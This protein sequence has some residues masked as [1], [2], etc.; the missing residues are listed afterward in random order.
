MGGV[1]KGLSFSKQSYFVEKFY[2]VVG[3]LC[4]VGWLEV[5]DKRRVKQRL[6]LRFTTF[7]FREHTSS[8]TRGFVV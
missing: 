6:S 1:S 8:I 2:F 3:V 4:S 5:R 7:R